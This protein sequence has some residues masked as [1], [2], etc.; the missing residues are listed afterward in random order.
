MTITSAQLTIGTTRSV[1]VADDLFPES[2]HL[3]SATGQIFIGGED[4]TAANG[5]RL[6]NGDKVTIDNH[7]NPIY[8]V[9]ASGTATLYTLVISK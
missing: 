3:H 6:D 2:V 7:D 8:A 4:V 9:T 5:F 1:I